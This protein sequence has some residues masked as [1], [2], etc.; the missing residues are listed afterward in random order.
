MN[1]EHLWKFEERAG[2]GM[3]MV[4]AAVPLIGRPLYQSLVYV[5]RRL[6][7]RVT[8][9]LDPFFS[10]FGNALLDR[11]GRQMGV[12]RTLV[13]AKMELDLAEVTQRQIYS[14]KI[15]E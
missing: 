8:V 12:T 13:G 4:L 6:P 2:T 3:G 1:K 5:N 9:W 7:D 15:F 11:R 14:K 10:A